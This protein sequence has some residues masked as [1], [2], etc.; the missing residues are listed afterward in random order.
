[1]KHIVLASGSGA[2]KEI[3]EKAGIKFRVVASNY[4]E[5]MTI[6]L[7]PRKLAEFLSAG[8]ANDVANRVQDSLVIGADSFAVFEGKLLGKP[9]TKNKAIEMLRSLSG[10]KHQFITG[11]TIIDSDSGISRS[12]S[13][14]SKVVF[15]KLS[16]LDIQNYV[17]SENVLNKAGAYALQGQGM[18]LIERIEGDLNNVKGL[19]LKH[20]LDMLGEFGYDPSTK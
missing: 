18:N 3:L 19:P 4:V 9:H 11:F 15:K 5:D 14:V 7:E 13:V 20:V 16:D 1:M 2:R 12:Y 8:K 6:A 17:A 10:K